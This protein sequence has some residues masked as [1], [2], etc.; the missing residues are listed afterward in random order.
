MNSARCQLLLLSFLSVRPDLLR[1]NAIIAVSVCS[2]WGLKITS[3]HQSDSHKLT[4]A[5]KETLIL[6]KHPQIMTC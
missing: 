5:S 3:S 2:F 4:A 6:I 1:D